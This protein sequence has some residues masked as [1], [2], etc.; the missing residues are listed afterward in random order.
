LS[1]LAL[2]VTYLAYLAI[3]MIFVFSLI[4]N[5]DNKINSQEITEKWLKFYLVIF[6]IITL[7]PNIGILIRRKIKK[8]REKFNIAFSVF[9]A[10]SLIVII[11]LLS[12]GFFGVM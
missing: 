12:S 3:Y 6:L 8:S 7:I 10:F 2:K 4:F 1:T 11:I 5:P 9:N